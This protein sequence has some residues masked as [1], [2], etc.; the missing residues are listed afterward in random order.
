MIS[1][2]TNSLTPLPSKLAVEK[3]F[4]FH[5]IESPSFPGFDSKEMQANLFK[6]GMKDHTYLLRFT[7]D[8]F[9][10][11]HDIDAFV[12]DFFNDPNVNGYIRVLGTLDRWGTIGKV[13]GVKKEE[14]MHSVTSLSFFDRLYQHGMFDLALL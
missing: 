10:Q 5:H 4:T 9:F 11:P 14:T 1:S 13:A 8:S 7:Y 3:R 12:K 6:W 2:E